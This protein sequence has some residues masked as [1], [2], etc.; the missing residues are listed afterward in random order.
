MG[1]EAASVHSLPEAVRKDTAAKWEAQPS[2]SPG[3]WRQ[4]RAHGEAFLSDI[5]G[6]CT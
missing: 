1:P 2:V 4:P 5:L 6:A 3:P